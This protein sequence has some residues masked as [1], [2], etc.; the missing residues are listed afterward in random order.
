MHYR[1]V[2][3]GIQEPIEWLEEKRPLTNVRK[4]RKARRYR[5]GIRYASSMESTLKWP[6]TCCVSKAIP[7]V[8][9]CFV[10]AHRLRYRLRAR[11][12]A[13]Y[14]R[15]SPQVHV[16]E[17]PLILH[18]ETV[19]TIREDVAAREHVSGDPPK[20][21]VDHSDATDVYALCLQPFGFPSWQVR[22]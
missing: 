5:L 10:Q 13:R 12:E 3:K 15:S 8:S 4:R 16:A 19:V 2:E 20:G 22:R 9:F 1:V 11:S 14:T 21:T 17:P 18:L 6:R 7:C